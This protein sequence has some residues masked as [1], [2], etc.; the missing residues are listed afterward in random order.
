[1]C[2]VTQILHW[3]PWRRKIVCALFFCAQ[4]PLQRA[5]ALVLYSYDPSSFPCIN[6]E[7]LKLLTFPCNIHLYLAYH[8][9]PM[10]YVVLTPKGTRLR[11]WHALPLSNK[12]CDEY[13]NDTRILK[14]NVENLLIN[15][16]RGSRAWLTDTSGLIQKVDSIANTTMKTNPVHF[17]ANEVLKDCVLRLARVR[18]Q[19]LWP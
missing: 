15:Q 9:I 14:K 13:G 7:V 11:N 17:M 8:V 1:M 6:L 19:F 4:V 2:F 16:H 12:Y 5:D 3:H 10:F 18:P